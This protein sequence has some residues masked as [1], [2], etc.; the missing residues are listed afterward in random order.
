MHEGAKNFEAP[1]LRIQ[2]MGVGNV[3]TETANKTAGR[4]LG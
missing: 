4:I 2:V 1:P 3:G